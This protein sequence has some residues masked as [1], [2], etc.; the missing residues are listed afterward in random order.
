MSESH[1]GVGKSSKEW[2]R[3]W[4]LYC[5]PVPFLSSPVKSAVRLDCPMVTVVVMGGTL[6]SSSYVK[7]KLQAGE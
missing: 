7:T 2:L 5:W 6:D 3:T 4:S 1:S